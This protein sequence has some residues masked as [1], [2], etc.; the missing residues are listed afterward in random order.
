M[1]KFLKNKYIIAFIFLL[2]LLFFVFYDN[3]SVAVYKP[4]NGNIKIDINGDGIEDVISVTPSD[5]E[6]TINN[7][8]Y[9]VNSIIENNSNSSATSTWPSKVFVN[10]DKRYTKPILIIQSNENNKAKVSVVM[11]ENSSFNVLYSDNKNIFGILDSSSSR[12][13][14]YYLLNSYSLSSS[15]SSFMILD[16]K[17]VDITKDTFNIPGLREILSFIDLIQADYEPYDLPPLF[18]ENIPSKELALLWNLSKDT[19]NYSF[20]DAFFYD[21]KVNE[22]GNITSIKWRLTF[23]RYN[24]GS[25]DSSKEEKVIYVTSTFAADNSFKISSISYE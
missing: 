14:R 13:A 6:F 19:Y 10:N 15:L 18:N 20:Q 2:S 9:S 17:S 24:K 1:K 12:T 8:K 21:N 22:K 16:N 23:E 5:S 4:V 3:S 7:Q 25:D 11:W